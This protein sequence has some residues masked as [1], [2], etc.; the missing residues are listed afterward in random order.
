MNNH[1]YPWIKRSLSIWGAAALSSFLSFA[2]A[3]R[4]A[5]AGPNVIQGAFLSYGNKTSPMYSSVKAACEEGFA[6]LYGV[7]PFKATYAGPEAGDYNCVLKCQAT[8]PAKWATDCGGGTQA[9]TGI[10]PFVCAL[11][12]HLKTTPTPNGP[13][14]T[15]DIDL[16]DPPKTQGHPCPCGQTPDGQCVCP[17]TGN[18]VH[19]GTGNKYQEE[20][21]YVGSGP[22]PLVWRRT[23]NATN[24][25]PLRPSQWTSSYSPSITRIGGN[26]N[27]N[28]TASVTRPDGRIYRF[29]LPNQTSDP[30]QK[31]VG[32]WSAEPDVTDK[33][34]SL[35][36]NGDTFWGYGLCQGHP[37]QGALAQC[38]VTEGYCPAG[39]TLMSQ[40]D[41]LHASYQCFTG[42]GGAWLQLPLVGVVQVTLTGWKYTTSNGDLTE[43]FDAEGK[44]LS[45]TNRAG[46][47]Q[48]LTYSDNTTP[49][50]IAP[51]PGLLLRVT[52]PFG[53]H[54]D[55]AYDAQKRL[56]SMTDPGGGVTAYAYDLHGEI[57]SVIYPSGDARLYHYE[58]ADR[59]WLLT[60]ITDENGDRFATYGYD[61]QGRATF[62][63]HAGGAEH[64]GF[65]Y[66]ANG[67]TTVADASNAARVFG[68]VRTWGVARN[69]AV[70][71]PPCPGCGEA[72]QTFDASGFLSSQ[73][74]WNG[75]VSCFK[76]DVRGL[77]TARVEGLSGACPANLTLP[78]VPSALP[79][80]KVTTQWHPSFR[81][82]AKVAEPL[83]ITTYVY[84][85]DNGASCGATGA[86]CAKTVQATSDAKGSLGFAAA[87]VGTPRT[88]SYTYNAAGQRL[89]EDG[90][91]TDVQDVTTTT[92][93][94]QGDVATVTDALGH[95]TSFPS[96]DAHGKPLTM[97]DPNGLTT[98]LAYDARQRLISS[99]VGGELTTYE[100]DGV[101]QLTRVSQPDGSYIEYTYDAAHRRTGVEDNLG[102][103]VVFTLDAMGNVVGEDV[104]DPAHVLARTHARVYDGANRLSQEIGAAGQITQYTHD[105]QGNI[106]SVTDPLG[107]VTAN[108]YDAL[109]RL[110]QVIDPASGV[111]KY[112]YNALDA[113][114]QVTDPRSLTT[115]YTID[116][117]GNTT[118][119]TSPDTGVSSS[120]YDAAGNILT[121]TDAK[122]QVTT[123]TYD[124]LDRVTSVTFHDGS[125]QFYTYDQGVNGVGRRT[126]VTEMTPSDDVTLQIA[127][128]YDPRGRVI[129]E[130]R[131]IAGV[132]HVTA[133]AYDA[134]GH[135]VS[136]T[137]PSGREVAYSYD[138]AGRVAGVIT[139]KDDVAHAVV[140]AVTYQPFGGVKGLVYG[141]GQTYARQYDLDGRVAS[142][143][144]GGTLFDIGFDP[145]GR[146]DHLAESGNPASAISYGYDAL[147]RLL[148]ATTPSGSFGYSYDP[149]GNRL[150]RTVGDSTDA[151]VYSATSNRLASLTPSNGPVR[152]F[153]FD[154]NGSTLSDGL[155][156]LTYDARGRL[157]H[158]TTAQGTVTFQLNAL[159]Q[160]VVKTAPGASGPV[161]TIF[162]YD[163]R[164]HLIAESDPFGA[165]KREYLYLDEMPIGVIQ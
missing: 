52:E 80:R 28:P 62:T 86:L 1:L 50:E 124:A 157:I 122:G 108:Q 113:L 58:D 67:T 37:S 119:Q 159:G 71:G 160:R 40:K 53:R 134:A 64:T 41:P 128:S 163:V 7:Y 6:A 152:S 130:T 15:C 85:G 26:R 36:A 33:L 5:M 78:S 156:Q 161:T 30:T 164:G 77:E 91:R 25:G 121:R 61:S 56:V 29:T 69:T 132:A 2:L 43:Q 32:T 144:L 136:M 126:G 39:I 72:A 150:S 49:P 117:L 63:E 79:A 59:P 107:H 23:Y 111:T 47:T 114:T 105:N 74:D 11:P 131:T 92:Y 4:E 9:Y 139:T 147:D 120:T 110:T 57:A 84:D 17:P 133:Y 68:F 81:S 42:N 148:L 54:L 138:A 65:T 16:V 125:R 66:N 83:R 88:W 13:V 12:S 162:H 21:D 24:L 158:V 115:S 22:F 44:L 106:T 151:Y 118:Q 135:M 94:A 8:T 99:S 46:L 116:G 19:A 70:T 38:L 153:L 143:T 129:T 98:T 87:P 35:T 155:R 96:H 31:L 154:A 76:R 112:G 104:L 20:V 141:N 149:V 97:V 145:A 82:R 95:V 10:Y 89:T 142:Y 75:N 60:G 27:A 55:L 127:Y 103:H 102:D 34:E 14:Y 51:V 73:T 137:Y 18:P 101:G 123:Y 165:V 100:Y 140:S 45:I 146:I 109:N 48:T 93:D 90:P 3:P